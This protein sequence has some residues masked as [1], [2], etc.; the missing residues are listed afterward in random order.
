MKALLGR[1][2]PAMER[3]STP[4]V[5]LAVITLQGS[6]QRM[7]GSNEFRTRFWLFAPDFPFYPSAG[8]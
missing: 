3:F 2:F 1:D 7:R 4:E 5:A 6:W 8:F